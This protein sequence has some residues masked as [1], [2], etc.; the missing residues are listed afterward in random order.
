M[1]R[2]DGK[3]CKP[4]MPTESIQRAASVT[5]ASQLAL[6]HLLHKKGVLSDNDVA[7]YELSRDLLQ[8]ALLTITQA[9]E[10]LQQL[11][12][13]DELIRAQLTGC[14]LDLLRAVNQVNS[15][16]PSQKGS[17]AVQSIVALWDVLKTGSR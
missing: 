16:S 15:F 5:A 8:Q 13:T 2:N 6:I 12:F 14:L 7:E 4:S 1:Q 17:E 11:D 3:L 9:H 10:K